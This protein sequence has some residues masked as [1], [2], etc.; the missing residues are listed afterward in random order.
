[1]IDAAYPQTMHL[2]TYLPTTYFLK[3]PD[4]VLSVARHPD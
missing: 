1:M 4:P 3:F 2:P